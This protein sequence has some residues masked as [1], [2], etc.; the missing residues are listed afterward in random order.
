[1]AA[2]MCHG[3]WWHAQAAGLWGV[4][5]PAREKLLLSAMPLGS[6]FSLILQLLA[7]E[8]NID[9]FSVEIPLTDCSNSPD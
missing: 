3:A 5:R 4:S 7:Y 6:S 9:I 8:Q 2:G 1:M